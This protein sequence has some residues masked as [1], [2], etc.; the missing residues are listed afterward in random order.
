MLTSAAFTAIKLIMRNTANQKEMRMKAIKT[1]SSEFGNL[2]MMLMQILTW[3]GFKTM[4]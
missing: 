2:V 4:G 1:E 3:K